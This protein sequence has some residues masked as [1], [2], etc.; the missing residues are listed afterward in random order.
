MQEVLGSLEFL[1]YIYSL[2]NFEF[3]LELST[4]PENK[5]GDDSL[6]DKAEYALEYT[7]LNNF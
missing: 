3:K 2:F 6:W 7:F 5:L 4:R 1:E